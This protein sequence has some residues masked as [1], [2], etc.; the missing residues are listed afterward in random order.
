MSM[1]CV[2]DCSLLVYI[3]I[4][5]FLIFYSL[6]ENVCEPMKRMPPLPVKLNEELYYLLNPHSNVTRSTE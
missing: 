4:T 2:L 5:L 1:S 6:N 3:T